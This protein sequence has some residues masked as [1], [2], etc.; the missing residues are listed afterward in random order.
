LELEEI[1]QILRS[2]CGD[3]FASLDG[4]QHTCTVRAHSLAIGRVISRYSGGLIALILFTL[5]VLFITT[6]LVANSVS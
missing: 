1:L 6:I 5:L 3:P 4:S 2:R